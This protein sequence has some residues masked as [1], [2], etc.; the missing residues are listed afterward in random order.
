MS[1]LQ[2][3]GSTESDVTVHGH[4]FALGMS[5]CCTGALPWCCAG[6][7]LNTLLRHRST[8]PLVAQSCAWAFCSEADPAH[9]DPAHNPMQGICAST[10]CSTEARQRYGPEVAA[11]LEA[12]QGAHEHSSRPQATAEVADA[13]VDAGAL[14]GLGPRPRSAA[15]AG[16]AG[17]YVPPWVTSAASQQLATGSAGS[18]LSHHGSNAAGA[19]PHQQARSA[20]G[21]LQ[22]AATAEAAAGPPPTPPTAAARSHWRFFAA[23]AIMAVILHTAL[24]WAMQLPLVRRLISRFIWMKPSL[25][26]AT[27]SHSGGGLQRPRQLARRVMSIKGSLMGIRVINAHDASGDGADREPRAVMKYSGDAE[28]VEW[29]N[30]AFRK[31]GW[32]CAAANVDTCIAVASHRTPPF[33]SNSCT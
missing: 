6:L 2:R 8:P 29:F 5:S 20:T 3:K 11:W 23:G 16:S 22:Q 9:A 15:A 4:S 27:A 30:M 1:K 32:V 21:R 33:C 19:P 24:H 28:S 12:D 26:W 7:L 10:S 14:P 17:A 18:T 13:G 25:P 31:V